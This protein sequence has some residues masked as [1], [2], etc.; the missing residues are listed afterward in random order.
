MLAFRYTVIRSL[1]SH[2]STLF[3]QYP[4]ALAPAMFQN[5]CNCD[6]LI[7]VSVQH[8]SDKVDTGFAHDIWYAQVVVHDLVDAV[9]GVLLVDDRVK[10]NAESPDILLFAAVGLAGED[11]RGSIV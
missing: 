5:L 2:S 3:L 11:F 7:D 10:Q 6:P 1:E 8:A 4:F 9:E